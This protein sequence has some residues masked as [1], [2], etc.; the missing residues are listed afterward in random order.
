MG[1]LA[2]G[3]GDLPVKS[4]KHIEDWA[5]RREHIE[6]EFKWDGKTLANIALWAFAFPYF[7][8]QMR[9]GRAAAARQGG[10]AGGQGRCCP[11]SAAALAA[12]AV[13]ALQRVEA[14]GRCSAGRGQVLQG[15]R[16]GRPG[17]WAEQQSWQQGVARPGLSTFL[18]RAL[19][20]PPRFV[21]HPGVR[22]GG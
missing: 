21:Q 14:A 16:A 18:A 9:C 1:A 5:V 20:P 12:A 3:A 8:Y 7:V 6:N 11:P 22:Q 2:G 15:A 17:G 13:P 10:G 4:N 19:P